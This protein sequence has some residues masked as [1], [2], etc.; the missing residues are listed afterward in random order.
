ML[1]DCLPLASPNAGPNANYVFW[2]RNICVTASFGYTVLEELRAAIPGL[3]LKVHHINVIVVTSSIG[4]VAFE[5]MMSHVVGFP[6]PSTISE[7]IVP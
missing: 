7:G 1:T 6:L 4:A 5:Y 3:S 2:I